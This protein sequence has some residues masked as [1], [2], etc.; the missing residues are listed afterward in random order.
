MSK[1]DL[2]AENQALSAEVERLQYGLEEMQQLL[3]QLEKTYIESKGTFSVSRYGHLKTMIKNTSS[4]TILRKAKSL[5]ESECT[6][7]HETKRGMAGLL[8][9]A[10][11][12]AGEGEGAPAVN[13]KTSEEKR[14]G[15]SSIFKKIKNAAGF[16]DQP[17]DLHCLDKD[18]I[19]RD[20]ERKKREIARLTSR[21]LKI[22]SRLNTLQQNYQA[23]KVHAVPTRYQQLKDMIKGIIAE[24]V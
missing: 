19:R 24:P 14:S 6:Q 10:R 2:I 3:R 22:Y 9:K 18:D 7:A 4:D 5:S 16:S 15:G 1:D 20:N 13:R 11:Q 8:Q 23:S 12:F 17:G 21:G